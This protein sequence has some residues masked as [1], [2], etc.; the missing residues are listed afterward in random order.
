[1]ASTAQRY[2]K[3]KICAVIFPPNETRHAFRCDATS[4]EPL[5]LSEL[6]GKRTDCRIALPR[7]S[8][9]DF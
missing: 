9:L 8:L 1:M 5:E 7:L 6:A 2:G 4:E 3:K